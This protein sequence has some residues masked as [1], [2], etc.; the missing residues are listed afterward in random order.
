MDYRQ[1]IFTLT[2]ALKQLH[3]FSQKLN[4]ITLVAPISNAL[5]RLE[6][7]SFAIAVVGEFNRGKSTFI[8]ALLGQ[9]ILPSDIL[10]TTATISRITYSPHPKAK[11]CF[12]DGRKQEIDIHKLI[13]F[14]TKL[15][16]ES[17]VTA[18]T[19]EEAIVYYPIPF[20]QNNIEIIDTPGLNDDTATMSAQTYEVLHQC[21]AAIMVISAQSPFGISEGE[22]LTRNL[23][24]NGITQIIFV[25]NQ[26]DLYS[27]ENAERITNLILNRINSCILDWAEQQSNTQECLR[28]IGKIKV[29]GISALQALQAKKTKNISLLAQ[30]RFVNFE[31]ALKT[32]INQERGFIQLQLTSYQIINWATEILQTLANEIYHLEQEQASLKKTSQSINNTITTLRRKKTETLYSIDTTIAIT[33]QQAQTTYHRLEKELKATV[34]KVLLS[35]KINTSEVNNLA[36]TLSNAMQNET[37]DF[38]KNIQTE[39]HQGLNLALEKI[40]DLAELFDQAIPKLKLEMSQLELDTTIYSK[41]REIVRSVKQV[42]DNLNR[43][44]SRS[45]SLSFP[46][47]SEIFV[48]TDNPSGSGTTLGAV[49]G[50]VLTAGNPVG[51]A[52][53]GAIGA[54]VGG[55]M[56]ANKFKETYQPQV[57]TE[58]EKQLGLMNVNQTVE[59]Y[60]SSACSQL[61]EL[62]SLFEKTMNSILDSTQ[63][64]LVKFC[65][66]REAIAA[67]KQQELYQM[68]IKIEK[69]LSDT[70]KISKQLVE[71]S[72]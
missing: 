61:E 42:C 52:I 30:S 67:N 45:L 54:A 16:A 25:V 64:Q 63:N 5:S 57:M 1:S 66:H 59:E 19:I 33:K 18:A 8:N 15:T 4:L 36:S 47:N 29:H 24:A 72:T 35:N 6:N 60:I 41:V 39:T 10:A 20:C 71:M 32:L 51:G 31:Y 68:Q 7:N 28:K 23:L 62:Q 44:D 26:I 38:S 37:Q 34:E 13:D 2:I 70:Q 9:E 56:K 11:V 69:I 53:G 22:F 12:K 48:F 55:S 43:Q 46:T 3:D 27:P 49:I 17:E 40:R 21:N 65:G 14:V 58:I 50:F